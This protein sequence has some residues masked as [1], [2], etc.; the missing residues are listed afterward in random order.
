MEFLKECTKHIYGRRIEE[1]EFEI[2]IDKLDKKLTMVTDKNLK[3]NKF[4]YNN[5][6]IKANEST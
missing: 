2:M 6:L 3:Y 1:I 4:K 5:L